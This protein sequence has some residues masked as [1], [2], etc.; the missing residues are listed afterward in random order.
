MQLGGRDV[1]LESPPFVIA[2]MSGNH[3]QSLERA[4]DIVEA[5]ARTGVAALKI[6]TYLPETMTLDIHEGEFVISDPNSLWADRSLFELYGEAYTPWEWHE[7]IF[8][9]CREL[10][11]VPFSTPFDKTSVDFL[12]SINCPFYKIAS[13][14]NIDI[15][16]IKN[17]ARTGKP[18]VISSG[19]ATAAELDE[20]V[21]AIRAEGNDSIVLLKC[22]SSY[23]SSPEFSDIRT[24]PHMREL[25]GCE[26]GLSDHTLGIGVAVAAVALGAS[27]IEKHFTLARSD[28]GVDSA[29]SLEPSEMSALVEE[30]E[31]AWA[32]LGSVKYGPSPGDIKSMVFRR[33]IYVAQDI[34]KGETVTAENLR[35]IRPGLGL[36]PRMFDEIVGRT[37][38]IDLK[39]GTA[40]QLDHLA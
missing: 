31:R 4:L 28:G 39:R 23:P 8:Q 21:R 24:I 22:T 20:A 7:P 11:V 29:F 2:E 32:A 16:L 3:N 30:T 35:V 12:E 6:Q 17:V 25:F 10:G 36:P 19:M 40:L 5:A 27:V 9:R 18:I 1:G 33:S 14:E 13:F 38:G 34:K 37:A 15:P 26:V